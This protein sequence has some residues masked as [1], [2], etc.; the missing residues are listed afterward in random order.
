[1]QNQRNVNAVAN[2][3]QAL[4]IKLRFGGVKAVRGTDGDGQ[5]DAKRDK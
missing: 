3:R 1:M 2:S 5:R 4:K